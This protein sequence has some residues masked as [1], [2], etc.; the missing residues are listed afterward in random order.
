MPIIY[1]YYITGIKANHLL[2]ATYPTPLSH[3][4]FGGAPLYKHH[5]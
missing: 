3:A 1:A 5:L 4:R 2:G